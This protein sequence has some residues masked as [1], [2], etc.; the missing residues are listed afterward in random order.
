MRQNSELIDVRIREI[1]P[2]LKEQASLEVNQDKIM[3]LAERI[4]GQKVEPFMRDYERLQLENEGLRIELGAK[5][6]EIAQLKDKLKHAAFFI[7]EK[8]IDITDA[9]TQ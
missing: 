2:L 9:E 7:D 8:I 5:D 6:N 4:A 3:E 1:M